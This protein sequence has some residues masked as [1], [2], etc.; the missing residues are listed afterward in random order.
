MEAV[1]KYKTRGWRDGP[2]ARSIPFCCR[3]PRYG[4]CG[5]LQLAITSVPGD[6]CFSLISVCS[7][8]WYTHIH[9]VTHKYINAKKENVKLN[10]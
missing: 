7:C 5:Y 8:T 10:N 4:F 3:G 1:G 2:W 9:S 6:M